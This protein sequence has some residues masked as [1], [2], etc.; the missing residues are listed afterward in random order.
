MREYND[1]L[2]F[3]EHLRLEHKHIH[4]SLANVAEAFAKIAKANEGAESVLLGLKNLRAEIGRHFA[5]E[6]E[7][8][9]LEE[10]MNRCPG[11]AQEAK[12]I[13]AE[14]QT[15]LFELDQLVKK[16]QKSA[17]I[18]QFADTRDEFERFAR[19]LHRHEAKENRLLQRGMGAQV[20]DADFEICDEG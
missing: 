16:A 20:M 19:S 11:M 10:V 7:G 9:C 14:H 1:C 12:A 6:E 8:G 5:E 2:A 18:A 4:E 13:E 17:T 3:V 15:F